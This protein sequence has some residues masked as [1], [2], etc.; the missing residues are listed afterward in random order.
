M[1]RNLLMLLPSVSACPS[2]AVA[3]QN[4]YALPLETTHAQVFPTKTFH[5]SVSTALSMVSWQLPSSSTVA[6]TSPPSSPPPEVA[7]LPED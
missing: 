2:L 3:Q 6:V 4:L 1:Y 7:L 5:A